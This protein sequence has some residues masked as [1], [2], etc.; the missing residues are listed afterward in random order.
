MDR[1]QRKKET[2]SYGGMHVSQLLGDPRAQLSMTCVWEKARESTC[3]KSC[4]GCRREGVSRAQKP[5]TNAA[6]RVKGNVL[7]AEAGGG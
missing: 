6:N 5:K 7:P 4:P 1:M 2:S 3:E